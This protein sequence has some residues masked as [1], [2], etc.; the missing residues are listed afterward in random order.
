MDEWR[1][2]VE[3]S[4][5]GRKRV[6]DRREWYCEAALPDEPSVVQTTFALRRMVVLLGKRVPETER[7]IARASDNSLSVWTHGKIQD[8]VSVSRKRSDHV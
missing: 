6:K 3:V 1:V 2:V 7:F 5:R 8:T 4:Q